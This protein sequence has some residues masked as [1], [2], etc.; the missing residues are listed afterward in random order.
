MTDSEFQELADKIQ[1]M[2]AQD[3]QKLIALVNS[4]LLSKTTKI[5][6]KDFHKELSKVVFDSPS[7]PEDFS[8]ADVYSEHD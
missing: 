4:S 6:P 7:L 1:T 3:K 8:R 5:A 2:N